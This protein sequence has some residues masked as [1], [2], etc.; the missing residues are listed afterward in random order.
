[1]AVVIKDGSGSFRNKAVGWA[2]CPIDT[3]GL[4]L[5]HFF[6]G[7]LSNSLKNFAFDKEDSSALG[8]PAVNQDSISLQGRV[9]FI[10]TQM[11]DTPEVTLLAAF[12]PVDAGGE[13]I[14][15][16]NFV[17]S[18]SGATRRL[19][20][21]YNTA[22]QVTGFRGTSTNANGAALPTP[23]VNGV[24]VCLSLRNITGTTPK[25][26]V[27]NHTSGEAAEVANAGAPSLGSPIRIGSGYNTGGFSGQNEVYALIAFSRS[28]SDDELAKLYA[29]LKR[30]CERRSIVI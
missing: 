4:E 10:Q 26:M 24:P 8:A 30:Y 6:G 15:A 12:K 27:K 3:T 28:V 9:N 20:L 16:G 19:A 25:I 13:A 17:A 2:G 14:V 5:A 21:F 7:A 29:W 1:M 18:T 23:I 11:A 22:K